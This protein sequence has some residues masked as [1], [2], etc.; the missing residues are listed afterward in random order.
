[1]LSRDPNISLLWSEEV[2]GILWFYKHFVPLGLNATEERS[3]R[4]YSFVA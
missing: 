1:M 4:L 3:N 2:F